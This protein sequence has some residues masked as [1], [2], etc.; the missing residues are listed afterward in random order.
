MRRTPIELL[1]HRV[2]GFA[3]N[4]RITLRSLT[5]ITERKRAE[6]ALVHAKA[7][8]EAANVAKS[9][10]LAS[11]SHELRT[12][13]NAILGMTDLALGEQ[14]P[15]TVR[16]YL[17][18]SKESADL[19][20]ELLNEIL[21]FSRIEAGRFELESTPFRLRKTVEQ[22][23]KTLGVRAYEKGLELVCQ[24]ADELPDARRRRPIAPAPSADEPGEQRDQVHAQGRSRRASWRSSSGRPRRCRYGSPCR[25]R[26]SASPR[27]N[28]KKSSPRSP[29]P[30]PRP[31]GDSAAP[32]L[33]LAISQRLVNLMGGHIR[34]E[35]QPGKGSTFHFT[36]ALPI[37]E[38]AEDEGE[39][40]A[41]DQ[42]IFRGL[43]A[44]VIGESA[45]SR[46]ILQQTLASWLMQV[47][48][49]PDV[50]SG[51]TKIHEAAAAGRAYRVVL[52]DAVMP[53]I[54]GFTLVGW[55]QQDCAAGRI[56]DPHALGHGSAELPRSVPGTDDALP[57]KAG[58]AVGLVQ[59]DCEG[60]RSRRHGFPDRHRQD[61]RSLAGPQ[62]NP[63][64]AG[65][66]RHSGQ[67]EARPSCSGQVAATA[68][69][70]PR[71][72]SRPSD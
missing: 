64:R 11:M 35:S 14:L 2:M 59:R 21:D 17:Q 27:R 18:T 72:A 53:G 5:D 26:G 44:L 49:A 34:V 46:K 37:A 63:P 28:W 48:E 24:V 69:R 4:R 66:R 25:T 12:P 16:D 42:D 33:G 31:A 55:L 70:S 23:I 38:Q 22:V 32:A 51:L 60:D 13:M 30:T 43:P 45:T 52:A 8:A 3:G 50:P 19:L 62:P 67:P 57:G 58:V 9:Q 68:S 54:D 7:A 61:R 36:L 56:G 6:E 39:V 15:S 1:G 10:F 47:D 71:T 29:R 40:T 20:L 65:S 41:G